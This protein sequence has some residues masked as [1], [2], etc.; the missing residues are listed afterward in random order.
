MKLVNQPRTKAL[1]HD[2]ER[3][4]KPVQRRPKSITQTGS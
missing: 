3:I 2:T 1:A 4:I